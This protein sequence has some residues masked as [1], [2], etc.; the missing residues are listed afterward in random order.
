MSKIVKNDE[1]IKNQKMEQEKKMHIKYNK[2]Y[3][4]REDR[5]NRVIRSERVK[6][7]ER[8]QKLD[9]IN[10]RMKRI[11]NMQKDRYLLEEERRKNE[12]EMNEKKN[13]MLKRLEQVIK[14]D[15]NMTKDEIMDY[16]I[17][18]VEP[19]N[20]KDNNNASGEEKK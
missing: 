13:I 6:D 10:N 16:V 2:L 8:S 17:N 3:I 1:K 12:D 9:K 4:S 19:G 18:N 7:F 15:K 14:S 11:E 5:K 20:N